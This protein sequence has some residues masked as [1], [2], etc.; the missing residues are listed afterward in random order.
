MFPRGKLGKIRK[1]CDKV[2]LIMTGDEEQVLQNES[3]EETIEHLEDCGFPVT[4]RRK[5][6]AGFVINPKYTSAPNQTATEVKSVPSQKKNKT[7]STT[8]K[9]N[10]TKKIKKNTNSTNDPRKQFTSSLSSALKKKVKSPESDVTA[11]TTE[12]NSDI[13][14]FTVRRHA[15][16]GNP[17]AIVFK[18]NV[19]I[20]K[21]ES[22]PKMSV[23]FLHILQKLTR[24]V[25]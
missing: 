23:P 4:D 13:V 8:N 9:K 22:K 1:L 15:L 21:D 20:K 11:P 7:T 5:V 18:R 14:P 24:M 16:T 2:E 25:C 6:I 10:E 12:T 17:Q 3:I 19:Q